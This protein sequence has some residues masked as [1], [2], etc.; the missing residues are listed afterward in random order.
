[1][2][3]SNQKERK[4]VINAKEMQR[5]DRTQLACQQADAAASY[6]VPK[7]NDHLSISPVVHTTV[8]DA[9]PRRHAVFDTLLPVVQR[10]VGKSI[11]FPAAVRYFYYSDK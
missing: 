8:A 5:R 3:A 11:V 10:P 2:C 6:P 4:R 9:L 7:Y 1:M